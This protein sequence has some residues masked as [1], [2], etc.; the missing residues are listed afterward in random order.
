MNEGPDWAPRS[1]GEFLVN[2][3]RISARSLRERTCL[4]QGAMPSFWD[5]RTQ[6][7]DRIAVPGLSTIT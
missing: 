5:K 7:G 1:V 2:A 6:T 3:K 4:A